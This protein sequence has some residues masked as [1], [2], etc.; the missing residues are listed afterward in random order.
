MSY[1]SL[2]KSVRTCRVDTGSADRVFSER[3][4]N[5]CEVNCPRWNGMDQ[6]GRIVSPDTMN[7]E[8]AGC[9]SAL[10]R[11]DVELYHRPQYF[12]YVNLDGYGVQGHIP[13]DGASART[14]DMQ[15]VHS[16]VGNP[17]IQYSSTLTTRA[18]PDPYQEFEDVEF[19]QQQ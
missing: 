18:A 19:E 6:F 14:A 17:G 5:A 10:D 11:I 7:L 12:N 1:L 16:I 4:L 9:R 3:Y 13:A 15:G 2:Q 8:T